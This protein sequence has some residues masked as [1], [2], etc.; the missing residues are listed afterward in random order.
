MRGGK[1]ESEQLFS[2]VG[3]EECVPLDHPL[4][5]VNGA[6]SKPDKARKTLVDARTTRH[7]GYTISQRI[8]KLMAATA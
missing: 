2:Y 4:R 1:E 3:M 7:P 5:A 8:P 6:V